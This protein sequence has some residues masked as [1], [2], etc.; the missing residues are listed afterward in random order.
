M[1]PKLKK[2]KGSK[3]LNQDVEIVSEHIVF[4]DQVEDDGKKSKIVNLPKT[5]PIVKVN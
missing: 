5:H 4:L 1:L 3:D 2:I